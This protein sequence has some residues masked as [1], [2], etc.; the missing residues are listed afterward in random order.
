ML[1]TRLEGVLCACSWRGPAILSFIPS[2]SLSD[3]LPPVPYGRKR[4]Q[5]IA[6]MEIL[7]SLLIA[8]LFT[9]AEA[10]DIT[11][12]SINRGMGGTDARCDFFFLAIQIF[13]WRT[14]KVA[15]NGHIKWIVNLRKT[16]VVCSSH[17]A[18]HKILYLHRRQEVKLSRGTRGTRKRQDKECVTRCRDLCSGYIVY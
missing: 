15:G 11:K 18:I 10:I 7:T 17:L 8:A 5:R 2:H 6:E 14:L 9:M 3:A 13:I 4:N 1:E 16:N 12:V